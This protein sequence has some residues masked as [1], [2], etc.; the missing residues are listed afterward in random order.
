MALSI[1]NVFRSTHFLPLFPLFL[2]VSEVCHI[3]SKCW[4]PNKSANKTLLHKAPYIP[5]LFQIKIWALHCRIFEE[6]PLFTTFLVFLTVDK[7]CYI[8]NKYQPP[9]DLEKRQYFHTIDFISL[10]Y[11]EKKLALFISNVLRNINFYYFFT[12]FRSEWY[13]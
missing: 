6:Y 10:F 1:A 4:L 7:V 8:S 11:F 12:I 13:L 2:Q 5:P 3:L 9:Y